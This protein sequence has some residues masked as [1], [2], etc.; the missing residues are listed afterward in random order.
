MIR[1]LL[2][3]TLGALLLPGCA[4]CDPAGG[5]LCTVAG[6]GTAGFSGDGKRAEQAE[7][8]LPV[9]VTRGPDQKLYVV[10][11]NNH[12]I[13]AVDARGV[14]STVAGTGLLGDGPE[15]PALEADFNHPTQV[16]F[17][18]GGRL[19]IA[20]WHNSR[21]K[22]IDPTTGLMSDIGGT[23]KRAYSGDEGPVKQADLDLPAAIAFDSKGNTLVMD[24]ANQVIRKID[25]QGMITR[26]AGQCLVNE[27]APGEQPT[28]C[29]GT[30]KFACGAADAEVCKKPCL[31]G[32]GGDG[33][34]ALLARMSQ[35]FGQAADPAGRLAVDA[36]DN[37][38]F[39][40]S[41]NHR[42]RQIDAAGIITTVAG[43]GEEGFGGEGGP[44]TEAQLNTPTDLA[45]AADGTLYFADTLNSCVRAVGTDGI[46]RTVAGVC[47][48]RG[49]TG[50]NGPA[51]RAL[52]DRPY[53]LDL[54][55]EGLL[56]IADTY[57]HRIRVVRVAPGGERL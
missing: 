33:G 50:E 2:A 22:R 23:G 15:G 19:V 31:G 27:C 42:I 39:A 14:I 29:A 28:A 46:I 43:N 3:F 48:E 47:G 57:N 32:F 34:P 17:D 6:T 26:F 30:N 25:L 52:L 5:N 36:H 7:L 24:Q 9:D 44:A 49:S 54:T 51:S 45:L 13:R 4:P 18:P 53:G 12:R 35:P 11:F 40:D 21:I 55:S 20:A 56:Y 37:V 41:R 16:A 1:A 10:D 8:Y 38:Y